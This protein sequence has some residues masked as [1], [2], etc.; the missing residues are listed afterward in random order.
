MLSLINIM[1]ENDII[2][3]VVSDTPPADS[4]QS[5]SLLRAL[6]KKSQEI[7]FSITS[8]L[9]KTS[10]SDVS[11]TQISGKGNCKVTKEFLAENLLSLIKMVDTVDPIINSEPPILHTSTDGLKSD[12][13]HFDNFLADVQSKMDGYCNT[14][15]ANQQK[16]ND[17]VKTLSD[18][19]LSNSNVPP[20]EPTPTPA[21]APN[22]ESPHTS[23]QV[24]CP[25]YVS[26]TE[27]LIPDTFKTSLATFLENSES[28][29]KNIGNNRDTLY[30]GEYGYKYS[31][32]EHKAKAMPPPL[33]ELIELLKPQ[34]SDPDAAVNSCL[35][36]RYKNGSD[37][38]PL[39]R[40][41]EP[42]FN[43]DSEIMTVSIGQ[44]RTMKFVSNSGQKSE[45]LVLS[46][47]SVLIS[48][49]RAQD[50]W[51]HGIE[52]TDEICGVRYS[53]T[54]RHIAPHFLNSTI[55]IGDSNTRYLQFG[56]G[57][58]NFGKWMP[59]KRVQALHIEDIPGP[60]DIGP[61]RNVVLHTGINNVKNRNRSSNQ[62]LCNMLESKCRDILEVYPRTKIYLSLLL[63]TKLPTLNYRVREFN[64]ILHDISH[65]IKNVNVIDHPLAEFCDA[66]GCL[67]GELGRYDR[68]AN[69]PLTRDTLH[70]GK[71]GLRLMAKTI[72][73]NVVKS[74]NQRPGQQGTASM[75]HPR[76]GYQP[77]G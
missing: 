59:G 7:K 26:F 58:G 37:H 29:F 2:I 6:C 65:S 13:S 1:D 3:D 9:S 48:S 64:G 70:L 69:G 44:S 50:F 20:S 66:N 22:T 43:P 71:K 55:I 49:R 15:Q 11:S 54:L 8:A 16:L 47:K 14:W 75:G 31:G 30:F 76:D 36:T 28:E 42:V 52:K 35:V 46:D 57:K 45:D 5:L 17:M 73:S 72:K 18:L 61:Y 21:M 39:H 27:N 25:P 62:T 10:F 38:I 19:V 34:L 77:S 12:S 67:K 74:R 56:E 32:G 51:Q 33:Q 41:D 60:H 63:P 24:L 23:D 40:D 53:F 68:E 4:S